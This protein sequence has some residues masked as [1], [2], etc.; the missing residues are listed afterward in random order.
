MRQQAV[1]VQ[2]IRKKVFYMKNK[3]FLPT[4]GVY[5]R[6]SEEARKEQK[7]GADQ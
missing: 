6:M 3:V 2:E 1:F 7:N 4:D 5:Y